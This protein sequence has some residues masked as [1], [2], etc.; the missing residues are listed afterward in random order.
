MRTE[1][2]TI[3]DLEEHGSPCIHIS[4]EEFLVSAHAAIRN[5]GAQ[6]DAP[7]GERSMARAVAMFNELTDRRVTVREGWVFMALLKLSRAQAGIFHAD[8]Y[9]DASGY[10]GLAGEAASEELPND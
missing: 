2:E 1:Y 8:D 3:D 7:D 10:L 9:V 6:R 4:A 5:R